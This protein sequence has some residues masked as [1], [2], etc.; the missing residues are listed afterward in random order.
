MS[1][2]TSLILTFALIL[3]GTAFG[4]ALYAAWSIIRY[5]RHIS[6][7]QKARNEEVK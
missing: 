2:T 7:W 6:Q 1:D 4:T 5:L 3:T